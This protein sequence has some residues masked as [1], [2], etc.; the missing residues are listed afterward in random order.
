LID[1]LGGH[2]LGQALRR[3]ALSGHFQTLRARLDCHHHEHR[4]QV[5]A[6]HHY[7]DA[8]SKKERS[9]QTKQ[10]D[11]AHSPK[12]G[13]LSR[14]VPVRSYLQRCNNPRG[15]GNCETEGVM[16]VERAGGDPVFTMGRLSNSP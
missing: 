9:N 1:E 2:A 12:S 7:A 4:F 3:A 8:S 5:L 10:A 16:S 14:T 11:S 15:I 6:A 13:E